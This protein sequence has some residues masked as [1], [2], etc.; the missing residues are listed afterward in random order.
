M[1]V[2]NLYLRERNLFYWTKK[3]NFVGFSDAIVLACVLGLVFNYAYKSTYKSIFSS[4]VFSSP[5]CQILNFSICYSCSINSCIFC[6][7]PAFMISI[8]LYVLILISQLISYFGFLVLVNSLFDSASSFFFVVVVV[9]SVVQFAL[10][11]FVSFIL[12]F[13]Q[14][15]I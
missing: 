13:F 4:C 15:L 14:S 1:V 12:V 11:N 3:E 5:C 10:Q 2:P 7:G 8:S 9:I 6:L